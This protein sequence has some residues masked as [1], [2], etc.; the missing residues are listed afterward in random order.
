[1][2]FVLVLLLLIVFD[3]FSHDIERPKKT[4]YNKKQKHSPRRSPKQLAKN[5][6]SNWGNNFR[7]GAFI[8]LVPPKLV[9]RLKIWSE[10]ETHINHFLCLFGCVK[11]AVRNCWNYVKEECQ[12]HISFRSRLF[13]GM[14]AFL[15]FLTCPP[16]LKF[17]HQFT[18]RERSNPACSRLHISPPYKI[19]SLGRSPIKPRQ[20]SGAGTSPET[21][22]TL[23]QG[24]LLHLF[25]FTCR[26][27]NAPYLKI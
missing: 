14:N 20:V 6:V 21:G 24:H 15:L 10:S 2:Q 12:A 16:W 7:F 23:A 13:L 26:V 4:K 25:S 3:H 9:E 11:N 19:F 22:W 5:Y 18:H 27:E 8:T 1:M 17:Y